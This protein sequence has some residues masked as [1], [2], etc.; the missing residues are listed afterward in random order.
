MLFTF[1]FDIDKNVIELYYHKNV[2]L[3]CQN[4]IDVALKCDQCINQSKKNNIILNVAIVALEGRLLFIAFFD[5]HSIISIGE[6]KLSK[7][8]SS[9]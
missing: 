7:T 8:S 6:V 4:L 5:P 2:K 1:A 3:F 9:T